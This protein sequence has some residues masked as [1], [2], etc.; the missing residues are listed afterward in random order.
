M[1]EDLR[2]R[3]CFRVTPP[4]KASTQPHLALECRGCSMEK[5]GQK[6]VDG[7]GWAEPSLLLAFLSAWNT[8]TSSACG[9]STYI[10]DHQ[11]LFFASLS[12]RFSNPIH[13]CLAHPRRHGGSIRRGPFLAAVPQRGGH[14]PNHVARHTLIFA[15]ITP[16]F[17]SVSGSWGSCGAFSTTLPEASAGEVSS[18]GASA[19]GST[20]VHPPGEK[21]WTMPS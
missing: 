7:E 8:N 20:T 13:N 21:R 16:P 14:P 12:K 2:I 6:T 4:T 9:H 5:V 10:G 17:H 11:S 3:D 19:R 1:V 15:R 18:E